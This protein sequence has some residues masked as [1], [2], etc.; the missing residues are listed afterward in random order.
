[1]PSN[2]TLLVGLALLVV[3][4]A[5]LSVPLAE[6]R[7]LDAEA[8]HVADRLEDAP[9][10]ADWGT[11][12][13]AASGYVAVTGATAGGLRVAVGLPYAYTTETD[14]GTVYADSVS[15]A[16]YVVGPTGARRVSG[17]RIAPC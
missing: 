5:A 14:E 6:R 9:C 4:A 11:N 7:A 12:E 3:A 17:D 8:S 10:L 15:E 1:M 2:R 13:G 16:A